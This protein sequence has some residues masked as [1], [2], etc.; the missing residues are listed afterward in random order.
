MMSI[1]HLMEAGEGQHRR[2]NQ[3]LLINAQG[4]DKRQWPLTNIQKKKKKDTL[5]LHSQVTSINLTE[6]T[7]PS[8]LLTNKSWSSQATARVI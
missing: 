1:K 5:D 8:L 3:T 2:L 7:L 6:V 4:K